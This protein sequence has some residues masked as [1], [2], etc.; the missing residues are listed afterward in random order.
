MKRMKR[1]LAIVLALCFAMA[2]VGCGGGGVKPG[3]YSLS[4]MTMDGQ[5]YLA[6]LKAAAALSGQE[7]GEIG[8]LD[9]K[10][11]KNAELIMQ[12]QT[13]EVLTYDNKYFYDAQTNQKIE[14]KASGSTI[15]F[16]YS[17]SGH[18]IEMKFKK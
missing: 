6:I 14:Y 11:D 17:E 1:V 16:S 2:L 13:K 10:D 4:T 5:D 15:T 7:L 9:I 18:S 8:Y 3:K 12:G